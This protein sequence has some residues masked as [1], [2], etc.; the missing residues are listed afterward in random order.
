[1]LLYVSLLQVE[2]PKK[3]DTVD[4]Q[5]IRNW[6][7]EVFK[8]KR[9][10]SERHSQCCDVELKLSVCSSELILDTTLYQFIDLLLCISFLFFNI[11]TC[12]YSL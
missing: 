9:I 7:R 12:K 3:P 2:L 5:E 6:R 1:M 4:E 11:F 10:N 8:R